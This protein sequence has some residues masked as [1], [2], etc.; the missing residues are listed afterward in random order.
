VLLLPF[1][2]AT[3]LLFYNPTTPD[4]DDTFFHQVEVAG[5]ARSSKSLFC[6]RSAASSILVGC[7]IKLFS[8]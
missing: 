6:N 3:G 4:E 8:K 2:S 7:S 1:L 5:G